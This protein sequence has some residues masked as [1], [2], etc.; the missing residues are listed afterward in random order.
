MAAG[1]AANVFLFDRIF[2]GDGDD[3]EDSSD[4]GETGGDP[5][6]D[7]EPADPD[8]T[9]TV[10]DSNR[11]T[12]DAP[13]HT[14]NDF[15]DM[16]PVNLVKDPSDPD[17]T[18]TGTDG[19]DVLVL[20]Y[21]REWNPSELDTG[22]IFEREIDASPV[23]MG[24]GNDYVDV[25][26]QK[27][28]YGYGYPKI[29]GRVFTGGEGADIFNLSRPDFLP[30]NTGGREHD[31]VV[32]I[33]DF[34]PDEDTLV[35]AENFF[36]LHVPAASEMTLE[37]IENSDEGYTDLVVQLYEHSKVT[38]RLEGVEGFTL[39]QLK[40]WHE[41]EVPRDMDGD[42]VNDITYTML[43]LEFASDTGPE[44]LS[45]QSADDDTVTLTEAVGADI[46]TYGGED[47]VTGTATDAS[48]FTGSGNDVIDVQANGAEFQDDRITINPGEGSD[49]ITISAK[50]TDV[51][52]EKDGWHRVNSEGENSVGGVDN[53][54]LTVDNEDLAY[55]ENNPTNSSTVIMKMA[56]HY[57]LTVIRLRISAVLK[58]LTV[59]TF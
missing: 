41:Q 23:D 47:T 35:L 43:D 17:R 50:D 32:T 56:K 54:T 49:Q 11:P 26:M 18:S 7:A 37:L 58:T 19:D 59:C 29:D 55:L 15:A 25:F 5:V 27:N 45:E 10:T 53:V 44:I 3:S 4:I 38:I 14:P 21:D 52:L 33:T 36:D 12:D 30:E 20:E 57:P 34:S 16:N 8:R 28:G 46:Q 1:L 22:S 24:A 13:Y 2:G 40:M 42:G 39:D 51:F 48:I 9:A 6:P 31:A